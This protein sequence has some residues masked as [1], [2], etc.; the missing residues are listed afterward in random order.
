[1]SIVEDALAYA[2]ASDRAVLLARGLSESMVTRTLGSATSAALLSATGAGLALAALA[3]RAPGRGLIGA[4]AGAIVALPLLGAAAVTFSGAGP[5]AGTLALAAVGAIVT[6]AL[7]GGA[8]GR[9]APKQRSSANAAAGAT[10]AGL[11]FA[12]AAVAVSVSSLMGIFRALAFV[13]AGSRSSLLVSALSELE[14]VQLVATLGPVLAIVS[15]LGVVGWAVVRGGVSAGRIGGAAA[16]LFVLGLVVGLDAWTQ[17]AGNASL[18]QRQGPVW[19]RV[20]GFTPV[21]VG[22]GDS[23][24]ERTPEVILAV[25]GIH[26]WRGEHHP[27]S[28]LHP[29]QRASLASTLA[30]LATAPV[31]PSWDDPAG[32]PLEPSYYPEEDAPPI[33]ASRPALVIAVD[34]NVSL[35]SFRAFLDA[36]DDARVRSITLVGSDGATLSPESQEVLARS[37]FAGLVGA[38][39]STATM[40]L[41]S[42]LAADWAEHPEVMRATVGA[43]PTVHVTPRSPTSSASPF[44]SSTVRDDYRHGNGEVVLLELGVDATLASLATVVA[45]LARAG[46]RVLIAPPGLGAPPPESGTLGELV[47]G[48]GELVE[49]AG[50]LDAP[51]DPA[52]RSGLG[53]GSAGAIPRREPAVRVRA[54]DTE[55]RGSLDRAVIQRIV[56][57]HVNEVRFC[58]EREL[59]RTPDLAGRVDVQFVVGPTGRVQSASV[60][61]STLGNDDVESC[62]ATAVRRWTFPAPEGGGIVAVTY[63]FV[64][65]AD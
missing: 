26:T 3:Q 50:E 16:V 44:D 12:A 22:E 34:A 58:Y 30:Q 57:R 46:Y 35:Q 39:E 32:L 25:D 8:V 54:G 18:V 43:V 33:E 38:G 21:V 2:T 1:M 47:G 49:G 42:S 51:E 65:N 28:V 4:L 63:P 23:S 15:A 36:A 27:A 19:E 62:I 13:D 11:A 9:D 10:F 37:P 45:D 41:P 6:A 7:A 53:H 48:A 20:P 17:H 52:H 14:T 24:Y 5:A 60:S 29:S 55:V 31:M 56:R 64:F 59:A 40:L 61:R